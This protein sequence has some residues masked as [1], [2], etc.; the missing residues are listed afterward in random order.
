MVS[1][2]SCLSYEPAQSLFVNCR[3]L[4]RN[5]NLHSSPEGEGAVGSLC[6]VEAEQCEDDLV[7]HKSSASVRSIGDVGCCVSTFPRWL[8]STLLPVCGPSCLLL[9]VPWVHRDTPCAIGRPYRSTSFPKIEPI[10]Y[11]S[12]VCAMQTFKS[13]GGIKLEKRRDLTEY[14]EDPGRIRIEFLESL[15]TYLFRVYNY[16]MISHIFVGYEGWFMLSLQDLGN[17][18]GQA[19][20]SL[21]FC[22]HKMPRSL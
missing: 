5:E 17:L 20:N 12:F 22:V 18:T 21:I 4:I 10:L 8:F 16:N 9:F 14:Q 11:I 1:I 6:P 15:F 3:H 2:F 13:I 7:R 19:T